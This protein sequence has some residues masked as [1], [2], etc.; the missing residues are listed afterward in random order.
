VVSGKLG[1]YMENAS[2]ASLLTFNVMQKQW[3][4][5]FQYPIVA[6]AAAIATDVT[7]AAGVYC[8]F[9]TQTYFAK[10]WVSQSNNHGLDPRAIL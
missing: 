7:E 1:Y 4:M 8:Q 10:L 9:Q 5:I 6:L 3:F 2:A